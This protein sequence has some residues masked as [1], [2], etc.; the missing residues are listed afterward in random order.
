MK[1]RFIGESIR[2]I[3]DLMHYTKSRNIPGLMI[4]LDFEK[5][6]DSLEWK[7][8][9]NVLERMNVGPGFVTST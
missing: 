9:F 6:F 2:T 7:Y 3:S 4:F 5:A 1:G 8:V